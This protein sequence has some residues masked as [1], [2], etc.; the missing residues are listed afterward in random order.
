MITLLLCNE[1]RK[2]CFAW[3]V[4]DTSCQGPGTSSSLETVQVGGIQAFLHFAR[5]YQMFRDG[6][7]DARSKTFGVSW[8]NPL[9]TYDAYPFEL[10][11]VKNHFHG[12]EV[13][14]PAD[15]CCDGGYYQK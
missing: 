9:P 7:R 1:A 10:S 13:G 2:T 11:G 5:R 15:Q 3:F 14:K 8:E 6:V 12:N 4:P